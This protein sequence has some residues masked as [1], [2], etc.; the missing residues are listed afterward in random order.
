[1]QRTF[2]AGAAGWAAAGTGTVVTY[3]FNRAAREVG[4]ST[5]SPP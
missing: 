3:A 1:M 4:L 5:V 2:R